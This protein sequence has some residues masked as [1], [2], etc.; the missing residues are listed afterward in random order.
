MIERP[1]EV[2]T[3]GPVTL[4]RHRPDDL[5]AV[6]GAVTES[7]DHLRPWM[8]WATGFTQA[9]RRPLDLRP[10]AGSGTGVVWRLTR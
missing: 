5:D 4:R 6:F 1:E 10:P 2:L 7:L 3:H 8:P 9:G